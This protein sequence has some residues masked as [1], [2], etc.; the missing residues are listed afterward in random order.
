[1]RSLAA[2]HIAPVGTGVMATVRLRRHLREVRDQVTT[3]H[4]RR[5]MT[6]AKDRLRHRVADLWTAKKVPATCSRVP[7]LL[8]LREVW[9]SRRD[10][11]TQPSASKADALSD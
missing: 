7:A 4:L 3:S 9:R 5:P 8:Q 6:K 11:N 2:L 10:S 1:M